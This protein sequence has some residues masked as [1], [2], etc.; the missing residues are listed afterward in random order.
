MLQ[1]KKR[2]VDTR[3]VFPSISQYPIWPKKSSPQTNALYVGENGMNLPSGV[4]LSKE[5]VNYVCMQIKDI[6]K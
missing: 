6:L 5:E 3:C 2:N 4:C 1:L